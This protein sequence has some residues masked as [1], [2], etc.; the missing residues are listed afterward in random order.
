MSVLGHDLSVAEVPRV[1]AAAA[2]VDRPTDGLPSPFDPGRFGENEVNRGLG[3]AVLIESRHC[4][5][6]SRQKKERSE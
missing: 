3:G 1:A 4:R 6:E 2:E 5:I